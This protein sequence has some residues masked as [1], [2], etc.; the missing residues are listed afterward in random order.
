MKQRLSGSG[1][2]VYTNAEPSHCRG[3]CP[4]L[5]LVH[6]PY[7]ASL[8]TARTT[9]IGVYSTSSGSASKAPEVPKPVIINDPREAPKPVTTSTWPATATVEDPRQRLINDRIQ[10]EHD[11][12]F[13]SML[14][15]EQKPSAPEDKQE[16]LDQQTP[17]AP[18]LQ[19]LV[20]LR[21]RSTS[22]LVVQM[23]L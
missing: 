9:T 8:F 5:H 20:R 13:A 10:R 3:N 11:S 12:A 21:K 6:D 17:V 18:L 7:S 23:L 14:V 16:R 4:F 1:A 19:P 2:M 15:P 22:S